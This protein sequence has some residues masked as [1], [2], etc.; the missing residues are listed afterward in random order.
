MS[1]TDDFYIIQFKERNCCFGITRH[2]NRQCCLT[3]CN[4]H[5]PTSCHALTFLNQQSQAAYL[6]RKIEILNL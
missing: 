1:I 2:F 4:R 3:W 6:S 5:S